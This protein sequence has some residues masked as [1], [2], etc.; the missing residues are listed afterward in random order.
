[1][2][3]T[4][5]WGPKY[6]RPDS[7][8]FPVRRLPVL[9]LPKLSLFYNLELMGLG[10]TPGNRARLLSLLRDHRAEILHHVNHIFD[11]TF[12]SVSAARIAGI[13]VVGSITT[14]VQKRSRW[15]QALMHQ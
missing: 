15:R 2:V 12:L 3:V 9:K 4:L 7:Q 5:D 14:P 1:M 6:A 11:T 13:P 8:P 10:F